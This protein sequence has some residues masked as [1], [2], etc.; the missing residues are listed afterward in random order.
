ME[1]R[2]A[3]VR[4]LS[5]E[6]GPVPVDFGAAPT[7][8]IHVTVVEKLRLYYGLE[9]RPVKVIEPY[10]MLGEVDDELKDIIGIATE[11]IAG[12]TNMFG[13]E[14]DNWKEWRAPWGQ[15]LL[16]GAGFNVSSDP[17]GAVYIYPQGDMVVPPC[18]KMPAGGWF[19]DSLNR[20]QDVDPDEATAEANLEEFGDISDEDLNHIVHEADRAWAT[21]RYVLANL[22]GTALGD[23]AVVP[24]PFAKAPKGIRD[25][26]EWYM[27]TASRPELVAEIFSRQIDIAIRNL[28]RIWQA[29]GTKIQ[30]LYICGTDFGTQSATFCSP[31]AFD[32]I[33]APSY[34]R[35]NDWIHTNT[36][37]KT[38][39]HSCGAVE[40][41]I[42]RFIKTGFDILNPVQCSAAG[43]EAEGL[44]EKYGDRIT[45]WGGGV[46]T[47]ATLPFGKPEEVRKEVLDRC[48]VFS[49]KGGFVFNAIHNVQAGT[50]V[51]NFVAMIDAVKQFNGA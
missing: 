36:S 32:E 44:K 6:Y 26:A 28:E 2:Q 45:F 10:Q 20:Q 34:R 24:A 12:R 23:I 5:H 50:P 11:G 49:P 37:W 31:L 35:L 17:E 48:R 13:F 15:D 22:G 30:A 51:E 4:A 46:N 3:V 9:P 38:F 42:G 43:M 27:L 47:Q 33:W 19:F 25:V 7:T 18:A 39:K 14:N 41:L 29:A 8:G 21:G 40:P 16:V 1:K